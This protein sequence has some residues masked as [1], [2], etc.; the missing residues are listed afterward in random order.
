[1]KDIQ[2]ALTRPTREECMLYAKLIV[3]AV[4][5]AREI[6][7]SNPIA[8]A[9]AMPEIF[10]LL[11]DALPI[12]QAE[13]ERRDAALSTWRSDYYDEMHGLADRIAVSIRSAR[14]GGA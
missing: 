8:A 13:A 10:R 5:A 12:I 9:A 7:P 11:N 4:G 2:D 1:M 6:N 14:E 3:A